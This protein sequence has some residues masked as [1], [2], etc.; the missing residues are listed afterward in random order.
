MTANNNTEFSSVVRLAVLG[1]DTKNDTLWQKKGSST[2]ATDRKMIRTSIF[3]AIG[4]VDEVSQRGDAAQL[5]EGL[6][7]L[8]AS[9]Q[10]A[11]EIL[12]KDPLTS[13]GLSDIAERVRVLKDKIFA[14]N[15]PQ[16][17]PEQPKA[18]QTRQTPKQDSLSLGATV[19]N[20]SNASKE[21]PKF[22]SLALLTSTNLQAEKSDDDVVLTPAPVTQDPEVDAFQKLPQLIRE[23]KFEEA[24]KITVALLPSMKTDIQMMSIDA[25]LSEVC[26]EAARNSD[27]ATAVQAAFIVRERQKEVAPN[28]LRQIRDLASA[29]NQKYLS[30]EIAKLMS[31]GKYREA[32]FLAASIEDTERRLSTLNKIA[33]KLDQ[34][35]DTFGKTVRNFAM[36]YG[37]SVNTAAQHTRNISNQ[38][39]EA[40]KAISALPTPELRKQAIE[41]LLKTLADAIA[42]TASNRDKIKA[43]VKEAYSTKKA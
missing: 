8:R 13:V 29:S 33:D 5:I 22:T 17:R 25:S 7:A 38:V 31:F 34:L 35:G 19:G 21:M 43:L 40:Q 9:L 26:I 20:G 27:F 10:K 6:F 11:Y 2:N 41:I 42:P 14:T 37:D 16:A 39:V 24:F 18:P 32:G 1:W 23:K 4:Q 36:I 12:E 28:L 30:E 15:K 3:N